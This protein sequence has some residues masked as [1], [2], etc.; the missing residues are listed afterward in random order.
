MPFHRTLRS[1]ILMWTELE[2][3][4]ELYDPHDLAGPLSVEEWERF[5]RVVAETV[6]FA[7]RL[8]DSRNSLASA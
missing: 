4:T 3:W 1:F 7:G 8:R 2:R 5:E 6:E